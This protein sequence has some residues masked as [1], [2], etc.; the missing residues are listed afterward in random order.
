MSK[1]LKGP[2]ITSDPTGNPTPSSSFNLLNF[3]T[4]VPKPRKEEG[5]PSLSCSPHPIR[6]LLHQEH[7]QALLGK[8]DDQERWFQALELDGLGDM[9]YGDS[10]CPS[11]TTTKASKQH[12]SSDDPEALTDLFEWTAEAYGVPHAAAYGR[13][14]GGCTTAAISEPPGLRRPKK[15]HLTMSRPEPRTA[16]SALQNAGPGR[17]WPVLRV[18]SAAL[19]RLLQMAIE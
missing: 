12:G 10:I 1:H 5:T 16:P 7:H 4:L 17:K 9:G 19:G 8:R 15:S 3:I 13:S 2:K 14:T 11:P 6:L 18:G